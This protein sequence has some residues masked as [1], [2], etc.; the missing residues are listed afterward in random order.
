MV[1]L[2][3]YAMNFVCGVECGCGSGSGIKLKYK[4]LSE[5]TSHNYYW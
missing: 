1:T 4:P 2:C 5:H 3:A